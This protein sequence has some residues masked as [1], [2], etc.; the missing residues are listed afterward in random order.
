MDMI[1]KSHLGDHAHSSKSS[2]VFEGSDAASGTS[3]A[4]TLHLDDTFEGTVESGG[5]DWVGVEL[6]EGTTYVFSVWGTGGVGTG[7]EDTTLTLYD[8][9]G[10]QLELADDT[11]DGNLFTTLEYTAS[12]SGTFYVEIAGF[13][14]P[15]N[16][17]LRDEID[18]TSLIGDY[19]F[20]VAD[21]I[22]TNEQIATY[23]T[24]FNWGLPAQLRFD[25]EAGDTL[26]YNVQG[27]TGDGRQL[28]DWA[29]EAWS[30]VT[31]IA[32]QRSTSSGAAIILDDNQA[33]AF[34]GPTDFN[35][36]N[37]IMTQSSVNISTAWLNEFGTEIGTISFLTYLHEI[38]HALGLGHSGNYDGAATYA[39]DA[40]Y[41]NDSYQTTVMSYFDQVQNTYV[42]GDEAN[43][44]TPMVADI[45]AMQQLY[46]TGSG[47]N[48]GDTTWGEDTNVQGY[49]GDVLRAIID[50]DDISDEVYSGDDIAF[51]I[52]DTGGTDLVNFAGD[53]TGIAIDLTPG[54]TNGAYDSNPN[55]VIAED[56][57]LENVTTG[58][59]DDDIRANDVAN[60]I[61]MGAGNDIV[62]GLGGNDQIMGDLGRDTVY[63]G[64]GSDSIEGGFS[65]DRLFGEGGNDS[66]TGDSA[67]DYLDGG[68]GNDTLRGGTGSDSVY[69][70]DGNDSVLGN[71]GVDFLFGGDG[72]DWM[73]PGNGADEAR[74]GNGNDT[75]I[76]RTGWDTIYGDAGD[77]SLTGSEGEDQLYGGTGND[78]LAG[79][80]GRDVLRGEDGDDEIFGNLGDDSIIGGVGSDSLYG[81]TGDDT[82]RG[83]DGDDLIFGAQGRDRIEGGEG[84]DT[85][86]GGT[87]AD[88][89]IFGEGDGDDIMA[90]FEAGADSIRL[91]DGITGTAGDGQDVIDLFGSITS[92]GV[93][94]TF[95]SDLSLTFDTLDS[96][97]QLADS[98]LVIT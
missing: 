8:N 48:S 52:F 92:D 85:L 49:L 16:S 2:R 81:A 5:T 91:E 7:I 42:S 63:G 32:F 89:F 18:D 47:A 34:A 71:T 37:G 51:T 43:P 33:G 87:Q 98:L 61:I 66:M 28:A 60:T 93:V 38:G 94:L 19:T 46:G 57:I 79:G 76:G 86:Y 54:G 39:N 77:D 44:I 30:E 12:T 95:S 72:D 23:M 50:D 6:E 29:F 35:P 11:P 68:I 75:I 62:R 21:D 31:G 58:S 22:Y 78:Y 55:V 45:I 4:Y 64:A 20:Q 17:A 3:T 74:G 40:L 65:D 82:I 70:G 24:E 14:F 90:S 15:Y 10:T 96:Y 1:T 97:D 80:S 27:L 53:T 25:A 88:V 41:R 67:V 56:T 69:G 26:T 83:G 73:S 13:S 9:D 84:N 59:G 36:A